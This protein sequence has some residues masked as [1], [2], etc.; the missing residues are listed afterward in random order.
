MGG[1]PPFLGF[2]PKWV[3]VE[4]RL[5]GGAFLRVIVLVVFRLVSLFY[6]IRTVLMF[7]AHSQIVSGA[8]RRGVRLKEVCFLGLNLAGL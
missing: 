2:L 7:C 1:L 3:V 4:Q 6:Y 8:E 5:L